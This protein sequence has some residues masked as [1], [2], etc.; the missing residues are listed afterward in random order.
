MRRGD[1]YALPAPRGGRGREQQGRRY[2]VV[3]Q[4]EALARLSTVVV[5]PTSTG[6]RGS[7][8]RPRV[9]I[10]GTDTH[11][12]VEQVGAV[13]PARLGRRVGRLAWDEMRSVDEGLKL[14]LGLL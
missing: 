1:V 10:A 13:D 8:F 2:A 9:E 3:L 11:V 7:S 14:V 6:A 12:L 5:A 4:S